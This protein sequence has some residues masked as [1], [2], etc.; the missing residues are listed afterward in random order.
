MKYLKNFSE[1]QSP[2]VCLYESNLDDLTDI[3]NI[4]NIAKD[5]GL[6]VISTNSNG[7]HNTG[8]HDFSD[9]TCNIAR[10]NGHPP[11]TLMD[12]QSFYRIMCQIV[13]RLK[14]LEL[15]I[16]LSALAKQPESTIVFYY[17]LDYPAHFSELNYDTRIYQSHNSFV[18]SG[19]IVNR[20]KVDHNLTMETNIAHND[21]EF[22]YVTD[23]AILDV[24]SFLKTDPEYTPLGGLG[25]GE[26]DGQ[27]YS[28]FIKLET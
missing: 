5:E 12:E 23:D 19:E 28:Y 2:K 4:L 17:P 16:R 18:P 22:S 15:D 26:L 11:Q 10:I 1:S 8:Y 3:K 9:F 20:L 14:N 25:T 24:D 7:E 6:H 21:V 27:V 13:D